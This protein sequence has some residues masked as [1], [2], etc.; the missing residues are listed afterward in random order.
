MMLR[1]RA[2]PGSLNRHL[3]IVPQAAQQLCRNTRPGLG[4][5]HKTAARRP[6]VRSKN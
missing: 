1:S 6:I 5:P 4:E 2:V 3:R